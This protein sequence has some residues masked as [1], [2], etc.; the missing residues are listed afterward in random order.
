[1]VD[2][3]GWEMPLQYSGIIQEHKGV[4]DGAGLFDVSH[5]GRF[6]IRGPGAQQRIQRV[7]TNDVRRMADG[8]SMY[9]P[10]CNRDGGV[11]DDV[12]VSRLGQDDF[13]MVVNASNRIKDLDWIRAGADTDRCEIED[14][15][16]ETAL[17]ALQGPRSPRILDE[18]DA[19]MDGVG[20]FRL[21]RMD[22][23]GAPC[24][25]SRT[26]YTGEDGF[27]LLFDGGHAHLWDAILEA[28][29]AYGIMPVGLGARDTLRLEAGMMLYGNDIDEQ[30]TPLEA[31]LGW[32]VKMEVDFIGREALRSRRITKKL[33]GFTVVGSGRVARKGDAIY[34][35][36]R[37]IGT[38][39][40][41]GFSPTLG[42]PI[43]YCHVPPEYEIGAR[44][45]V[46]IGK[47]RYEARL[48]STRFYRR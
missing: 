44:V 41:G 13:I 38:V 46:G 42:R 39:T 17:L 5:M 2:F 45:M 9:S 8:Q 15:T 16:A 23:E 32:T 43:G 6:R 34:D 12:I 36:D 30:T 28:G 4:R 25:V 7:T 47:K 3:Y 48:A 14:V 40:S 11:V 26:G 21:V 31:P 1:M 27:E 37:R 35:D 29:S 19:N 20:P 33:R 18:M 22:L 10:M 24:I